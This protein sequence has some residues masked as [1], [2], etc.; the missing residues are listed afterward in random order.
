MISDLC[1]PA[2]GVLRY[3]E[4]RAGCSASIAAIGALNPLEMRASVVLVLKYLSNND[5]LGKEKVEQRNF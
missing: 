4:N 3:P 1:L 2:I 5:V